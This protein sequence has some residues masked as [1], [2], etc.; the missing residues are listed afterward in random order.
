MATKKSK[1]N[2]GPRHFRLFQQAQRD[3]KA[4][5][6]NIDKAF[7][8]QLKRQHDGHPASSALSERILKLR[9]E[10]K[11]A[12]KEVKRIRSLP[13]FEDR[14]ALKVSLGASFGQQLRKFR[15]ELA[16]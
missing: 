11:D 4:V 9:Q 3:V 6:D 2:M 16:A 5:K 7:A 10:L 8:E 13:R 15:K 12:Q 14:N 1:I